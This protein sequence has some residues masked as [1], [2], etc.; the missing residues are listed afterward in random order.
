[1]KRTKKIAVLV[2]VLGTELAFSARTLDRD[3]DELGLAVAM[4]EFVFLYFAV[5]M[6]TSP[7]VQWV[8]RA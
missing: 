8:K 4:L 6:T 7:I 3:R 5:F 1:M 2:L